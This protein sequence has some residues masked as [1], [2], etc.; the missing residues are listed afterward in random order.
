M[1]QQCFG[2]Q[3][4]GH[5][6]SECPIFLRLKCKA[7]AVTLSDNEVSDHEFG[8]DEDGNFIAIHSYCYS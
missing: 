2:C 4:Y 7:M 8:G 5:V 6:K 3:G 1:G